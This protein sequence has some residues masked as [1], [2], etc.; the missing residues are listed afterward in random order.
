LRLK[1][2]V[3]GSGMSPSDLVLT[4]DIL[5]NLKYFDKIIEVS[6]ESNINMVINFLFR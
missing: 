6:I 2:R 3:V 1:V 4:F 5:I